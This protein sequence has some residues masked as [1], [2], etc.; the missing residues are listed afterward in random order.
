MFLCWASD[1]TFKILT[2]LILL[3]DTDEIL[4]FFCDYPYFA[5]TPKELLNDVLLI[6]ADIFP[7]ISGFFLKIDAML[8][9]SGVF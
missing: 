5:E 8:V 3:A 6:A 9:L 2:L 7:T 1:S 4:R